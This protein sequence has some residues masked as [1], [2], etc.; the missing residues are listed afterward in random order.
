MSIL[1]ALVDLARLGKTIMDS[2]L[3]GHEKEMLGRANDANGEIH[4]LTTSQTGEWV[5][6]G[7][8]NYSDDNDRA[9]QE[10]ALDTLL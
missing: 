2:R 10:M 5:E 6:I 8:H 3:T 4:I 1:G 9:V 7:D